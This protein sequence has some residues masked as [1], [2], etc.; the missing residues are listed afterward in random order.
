[1]ISKKVV[2][3]ITLAVCSAALAASPSSDSSNALDNSVFGN[4]SKM[5]ALGRRTFRFAT[6][7]DQVFWG[8]TLRL[9][10]AIEGSKFGGVGPGVS[11]KTALAVGLKVDVD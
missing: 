6:F 2:G 3:I 5:V 10:Q 11:P 7:G 8:D 9:H 1:M 4:S